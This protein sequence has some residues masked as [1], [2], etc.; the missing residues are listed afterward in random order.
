MNTW[1]VGARKHTPM[2]THKSRKDQHIDICLTE[3]IDYSKTCHCEGNPFD[4]W[5]L[6]HDA[7]PELN[8][9]NLQT[10]CIFLDIQ[11]SAPLLIGS[12]TGGTVRA[13]EIN[14]R[15]FEA[16]ASCQIGVSL[17]SQRSLAEGT[18]CMSDFIPKALSKR[19][20]LVFSNLGA[21]QLNYGVT[22]KHIQ[23]IIELTQCDA[24]IFHLNPLQ[25]AIQPEGNTDFSGL[26][27]KLENI[28]PQVPVPVFIKEVGAGFSLATLK[29]L[30]SLSLAGIEIAGQGGTSWARIE[31][32]RSKKGC[33]RKLGEL[34][35]SWGQPTIES[36][37][38]CRKLFPQKLI[39]ASGGIRNGI[40]IAK[41]IVLGADM[42]ALALPFLQAASESTEAVI[43]LIEQLKQE[44]RVAM[45]VTGAQD[46]LDLKK[47]KISCHREER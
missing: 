31:G 4:Q 36:L 26:A 47:K 43:Q 18:S 28:I 33:N 42:A 16:A 38:A 9:E 35:A 30:E 39:I 6:D 13:A 44:L 25:E 45:F 5:H 11:L 37:I 24:F 40:D 14:H 21:V 15:L 32:L 10:K 46:I 20:P 29:K 34:F 41:S 23:R 2:G 22:L 17:G 7:L 19:P 1:R 12:M 3:N 8:L 27:Q